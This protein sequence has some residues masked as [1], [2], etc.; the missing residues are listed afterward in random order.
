MDL[1]IDAQNIASISFGRVEG[2]SVVLEQTV[3]ARPEEYLLVLQKTLK[4]WDQAPDRI[5]KIFVITG[6]GSFT[7]SRVSTTIANA[8]A[9]AKD[10]PILALENPNHLPLKG[11]DLSTAKV[12]ASYAIPT[13]DRPPEITVSKKVRGDNADD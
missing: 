3:C 2:N 12:V 7:A 10:V 1:L 11:L 13:Y 8:L 6:P 4:Q 9:F 5:E